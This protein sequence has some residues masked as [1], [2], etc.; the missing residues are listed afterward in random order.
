MAL[1][2][3]RCPKTIQERRMNLI[4][5]E[6]GIHIRHR[7]LPNSHDDINRGIIRSWKS[8]RKTQYK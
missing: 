1:D 6:E 7:Y 5:V 3:I 4:A 2:W 8:Q